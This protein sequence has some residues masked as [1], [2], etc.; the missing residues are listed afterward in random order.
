MTA[1][2]LVAAAVGVGVDW[3]Q[4]GQFPFVATAEGGSSVDA[5]LG[6]VIY[7]PNGYYRSLRRW[8]LV[9]A[10]HGSGAI[11]QDIERVRREGLPLRVEEKADIRFIIAPQSRN[12]PWNVKQLEM[13]PDDAARRYRVDSDRVYL[14]G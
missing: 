1:L 5:S 10:L 9:L 8:P 7:L 2:A 11:G 13:L 6:Y 4:A 14:T 3:S 12:G